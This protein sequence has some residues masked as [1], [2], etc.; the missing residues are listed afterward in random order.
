MTGKDEYTYKVK[1]ARVGGMVVPE[2]DKPQEANDYRWY[3]GISHPDGGRYFDPND[4][5][6]EMKF[7]RKQFVPGY[8]QAVREPQHKQRPR[9]CHTQ[10]DRDIFFG[11]TVPTRRVVV[12]E[13]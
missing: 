13:A 9:W 11:P 12:T 7:T 3:M 10:Q 1:Y 2:L 5:D 4:W 6:L 8:Y